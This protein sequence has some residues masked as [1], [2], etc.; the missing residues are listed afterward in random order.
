ML[1]ANETIMGDIDELKFIQAINNLVS[2]AIKFTQQDGTIE[3]SIKEEQDHVLITVSDNGIGIPEKHHE[4]LFDK[5]TS[6]RRRGLRG[7]SSHGLG[8]SIIKTIVE[9]H[10]CVPRNSNLFFCCHYVY[11]VIFAAKNRSL[12]LLLNMKK[13]S[14]NY[15]DTFIEVAQDTRAH[16][17][18][19]PL[20]K[21]KKTIALAQYELIAEHPYKFSSDD[22]LFQVFAQR[23]EL[24]QAEYEDAKKLFF[25]KGQP[26][27]RASPLTKTYGFGIHSNKEGKVAL[28]GMETE[29]YHEFLADSKIKKVK[30]MKSGK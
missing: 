16:C 10:H 12:K 22:V 29:M 2:N 8:M 21:E 7:E 11:A 24:T 19:Q 30:A 18:V 1:A 3:I 26:C 23:N 9:W 20:L 27:L 17:G 4:L 25:S 5:F 28:F 6:A 14:T 15:Y 13:H